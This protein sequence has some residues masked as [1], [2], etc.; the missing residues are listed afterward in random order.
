MKTVTVL[1]TFQNEGETVRPAR[2]GQQPTR[3]VVSPSRARELLKSG[4]V[5]DEEDA[6]EPTAEELEELVV[7][8][9][10][11]ASIDSSDSAVITIRVRTGR[12]ADALRGM[13]RDLVKRAEGHVADRREAG[14]VID[15]DAGETATSVIFADNRSTEERPVMTEGNTAGDTE[16]AGDETSGDAETETG[17][18]TEATEGEQTAMTGDTAGAAAETDRTTPPNA[19]RRPRGNRTAGAAD[20]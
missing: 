7:R 8:G 15:H 2:G 3:I 6:P 18:E 11:S 1:K 20:A 5:G 14:Q 19:G 12:Q 16:T 17:T 4:L 13:L 10:A 9:L